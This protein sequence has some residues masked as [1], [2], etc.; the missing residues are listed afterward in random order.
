[1]KNKIVWILQIICALILLQTLFF[2]FSAHP[3]SVQLFTE[4]GMEPNGRILIGVLELIADIL[5]IIPGSAA[6]GAFLAT[7]IMSGAII[8]HITT[9]GFEGP[10]LSLSLL[11]MAILIMS[12]TILLIRRKEIPI[13]GKMLEKHNSS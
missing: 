4:L 6:Y 8:G 2:K 11:A 3:D 1:M 5:L 12:V 13:I 9:L 10:R 7:G